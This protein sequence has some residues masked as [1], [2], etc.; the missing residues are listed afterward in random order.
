MR[1][2]D[3]L[4]NEFEAY[5]ESQADF[6][7]SAFLYEDTGCLSIRPYAEEFFEEWLEQDTSENDLLDFIRNT[8]ALRVF[9]QT[10]KRIYQKKGLIELY[11]KYLPFS[12]L[13]P[14]VLSGIFMKPEDIYRLVD[15]ATD[16][17]DTIV[18]DLTAVE[19]LYALTRYFGIETRYGDSYSHLLEEVKNAMEEKK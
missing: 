16:W 8:N 10:I 15:D 18:K 7:E 4:L 1:I 12:M 11:Q 5:L 13:E 6:E 14:N 17:N 3:N 2:T 9:E 19:G